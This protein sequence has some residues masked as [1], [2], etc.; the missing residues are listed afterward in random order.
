MY[1]FVL[2]SYKITATDRQTDKLLHHT[3][4]YITSAFGGR[5]SINNFNG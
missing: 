1:D 3:A 5:Q 4:D 2:V